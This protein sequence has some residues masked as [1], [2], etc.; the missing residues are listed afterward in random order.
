MF[1]VRSFQLDY[2]LKSILLLSRLEMPWN[3]FENYIAH[4]F[5]IAI[6]SYQENLALATLTLSIE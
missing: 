1:D 4:H 6:Y 2:I 5:L 3:D